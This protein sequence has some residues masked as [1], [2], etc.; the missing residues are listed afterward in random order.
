MAVTQEH[1]IKRLRGLST[2]TKPGRAEMATPLPVGSVFTEIDTGK[3]FV[4]SGS[5]PWVRHEQTIEGVIADLI[6][7]NERILA[8]LDATHRGHE[9]HTWEEDVEL[10]E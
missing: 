7:V 4:W 8:R 5:W 2:D 1:A 3:R 6:D 9:E 10:E